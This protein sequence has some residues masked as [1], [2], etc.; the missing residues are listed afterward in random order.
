MNLISLEREFS[1]ES[2]RVRFRFWIEDSLVLWQEVSLD[3]GFLK[4]FREIGFLLE[5]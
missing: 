5:M 1:K 2:F 4:D 3:L